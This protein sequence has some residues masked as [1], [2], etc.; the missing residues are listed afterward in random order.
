R[1]ELA[2]LERGQ[3]RAA[4]EDV[5][6]R[7]ERAREDALA[8]L[9]VAVVADRRHVGQD[10]RDPPQAGH[11]AEVVDPRVED[12]EDLALRLLDVDDAADE[13]ARGG[14]EVA[15]RL[16]RDLRGGPPPARQALVEQRGHAAGEAGELRP[17]SR[18]PERRA[19]PA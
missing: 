8:W 19:E 13:R 7:A 3:V 11:P 5:E 10:P 15:A 16:E 17:R 4:P 12:D 6:R 18:A 14:D 2:G 1:H 9:G